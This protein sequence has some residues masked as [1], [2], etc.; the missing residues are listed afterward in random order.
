MLKIRSEI[1][2]KIRATSDVADLHEALQRA[3]ELEHA[4]IP[5]Y[6]TAL[7]SIKPR[8][9]VEAAR[10][11]RGVVVQEMLHM[12]IAANA[13]NAIGGAPSI[14]D[15]NFIPVFPGPLPMGVHDGLSVGLEKLTKTLVREAFMVIE[16]PETKIPIPFKSPRFHAATPTATTL[17]PGYASIDAFYAAIIDKIKEL[18]QGIFTG[19]P[20][21]QVTDGSAFNS[22]ELLFPIKDASDAERALNMIVQEGEGTSTSPND[23]VLGGFAHY[24]Q[25]AQILY[26]RSLVAD[27][28]S[29]S[30][31][32]Y[33]GPPVPLDPAGIWDLH[34]NAR[35][36]DYPAGSAARTC[37]DEF[38]VLYTNL[39]RELHTTFNGSPKNLGSTIW[40]LMYQLKDKAAQLVSTPIS[41]TTLF[42]SPTFEYVSSKAE[43]SMSATN[44][45]LLR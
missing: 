34:P 6:L 28:S 44:L 30:G 12:T 23:P 7:Y 18:G 27:T 19:D 4:T 42:A 35:A 31:Y 16:E 14:D 3:V 24:Y 13:L 32:S 38:N 26:G 40:G 29:P 2:E 36:V 37:A 5:V 41:G 10:I 22:S 39:L 45:P 1:V 33:S 21:R 20:A 8:Q 15:P 9:N 11:L 17:S 43:H 25:F